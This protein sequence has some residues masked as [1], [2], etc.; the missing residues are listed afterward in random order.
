MVLPERLT[1]SWKPDLL[2]AL[3]EGDP[4]LYRTWW[5]YRF[6]TNLLLNCCLVSFTAPFS[7]QCSPFCF[8][9]LREQTLPDNASFNIKLVYFLV[10]CYLG[11]LTCTSTVYTPPC[12]RSYPPRHLFIGLTHLLWCSWSP[13]SSSHLMFHL[14]E[15]RIAVL[16]CYNSPHTSWFGYCIDIRHNFVL[17]HWPSNL[18]ETWVTS[19]GNSLLPNVIALGRADWLFL[20]WALQLGRLRGFY[21]PPLLIKCPAVYRCVSI[22]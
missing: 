11:D 12:A 18:P 17:P 1:T 5:S 4:L 21:S 22:I 7:L 6:C 2:G 13:L 20:Y 16:S 3:E 8:V 10:I 9:Y 15:Q 19:L 14:E